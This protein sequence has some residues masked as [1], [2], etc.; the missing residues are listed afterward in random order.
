MAAMSLRVIACSCSFPSLHRHT[1]CLMRAMIAGPREKSR[2]QFL[3]GLYAQRMD[4]LRVRM[5]GAA[6]PFLQVPGR[7]LSPRKSY[8][9]GVW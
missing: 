1:Q 2:A 5:A 9:V 4:P 8:T 6:A 3:D 7:Y